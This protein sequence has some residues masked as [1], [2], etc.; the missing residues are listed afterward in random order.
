MKIAVALLLSV[1]SLVAC[2]HHEP[3]ASPTTSTSAVTGT[4]EPVAATDPGTPTDSGCKAAA[5][6][7]GS[8]DLESCLAGCNGL[9]DSVPAGARCISAKSSCTVQCNATFKK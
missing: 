5:A 8:K 6:P 3:A 7:T 4:A 9:S 1:S 2:A